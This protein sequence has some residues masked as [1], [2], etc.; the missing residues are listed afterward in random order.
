MRWVGYPSPVVGIIGF[1]FAAR[2]GAKHASGN[3]RRSS[4]EAPHP[5]S[6]NGIVQ[7]M[8]PMERH[9]GKAD[10][11]C[12]TASA[13]PASAYPCWCGCCACWPAHCPRAADRDVRWC[14]AIGERFHRQH[15][16]QPDNQP[17]PSC[18][19]HGYSGD[20]SVAARCH[21]ASR[22]S[23]AWRLTADR[24]GDDFLLL[25]MSGVTYWYTRWRGSCVLVGSH[26]RALSAGQ[27][28][29]R[30]VRE[31]RWHL[32]GYGLIAGISVAAHSWAAVIVWLGPC[33][34]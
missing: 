1:G 27:T 29:C 5:G 15:G 32:A 24:L 30:L 3:P 14:S 21:R 7:L 11:P 16:P 31:A 17:P 18:E 9:P 22:T 13:N 4:T 26:H 8:Q 20:Q 12:D 10:A 28:P 23:S 34:R 6:E 19:P 33:W 25:W 2:E